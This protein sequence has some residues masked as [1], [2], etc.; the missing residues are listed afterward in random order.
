MTFLIWGTS[1]HIGL[2]YTGI[3]LILFEIYYAKCTKWN[4]FSLLK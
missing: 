4:K 2:F 3:Q 1:F